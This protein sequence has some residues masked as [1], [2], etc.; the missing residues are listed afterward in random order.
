MERYTNEG[1]PDTAG[2]LESSYS[3]ARSALIDM[4]HTD[5]SSTLALQCVNITALCAL[6]K[7]LLI[8]E[9][10]AL[11]KYFIILF[12]KIILVK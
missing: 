3:E 9:T 2:R 11:S 6:N 12:L 5:P 4:Q 7:R 10:A 1:L 8:I